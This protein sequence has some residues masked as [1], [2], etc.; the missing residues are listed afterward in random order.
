MLYYINEEKLDNGKVYN[1]YAKS[2]EKAISVLHNLNIFNFNL[3]IHTKDGLTGILS[4][5]LN[6]EICKDLKNDNFSKYNLG[7]IG[8]ITEK[9][10]PIYQYN[11][12]IAC[13]TSYNYLQKL[14]KSYPNN[15]IIYIPWTREEL[16]LVSHDNN[17]NKI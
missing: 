2:V 9:I 12:I 6:N 11:T 13:F 10:K 14:I 3:A 8:L 16:D 1:D 7:T 5:V 15:N 17:F 4:E